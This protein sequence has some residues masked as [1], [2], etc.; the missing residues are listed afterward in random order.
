M[1]RA[2]LFLLI[3]GVW[4]VTGSR[5]QSPSAADTSTAAIVGAAAA[6]VSQYQAQLTSILADESYTQRIASQIP[7]DTTIPS[8]RT[9]KSE[10]AFIFAPA[11]RVWMAIRDVIAVDRRPV[12]SRPD[13][14][15]ALRTL[16]APEV[17]STFKTYNSRFNLGRVVRNFNEPTL[18]LLVLDSGHRGRFSFKSTRVDRWS[19]PRLVTLAFE[20]TT[21]PTLISDLTQGPA[22]SKGEFVVEAG[23]GRIRRALLKLTIGGVRMELLTVYSPEKRLGMW[24]PTQFR[25]RYEDGVAV[26]DAKKRLL[27][28]R[29]RYEEIVCEA[30]YTNFRRFE[31]IVRVK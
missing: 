2:L 14:R 1:R 15:E 19:D 17:A 22:F 9:L 8:S 26:G 31:V 18:S 6:Y 24:V 10:I 5:A 13:L 29:A 3:G 7:R 20:E 27:D 4:S 30:R 11:N 28:A 12:V 23:T 21:P 16:P 25:E